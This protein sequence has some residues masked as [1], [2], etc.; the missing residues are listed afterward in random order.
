MVWQLYR[1][2]NLFED[3]FPSIRRRSLN[4][5]FLL[6]MSHLLLFFNLLL[7]FLCLLGEI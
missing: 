1:P 7:L 3:R 4:L 5:L 2:C 6:S